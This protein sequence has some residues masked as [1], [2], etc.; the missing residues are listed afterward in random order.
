MKIKK[1]LRGPIAKIYR[2]AAEQMHTRR[3]GGCCVAIYRTASIEEHGSGLCSVALDLFQ[4]LYK[5][6][7]HIYWWPYGDKRSRLIALC[8]AAAIAE[9]GGL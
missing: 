4:V 2:T 7:S 3:A 1:K 9:D 5:E 8:L 6:N